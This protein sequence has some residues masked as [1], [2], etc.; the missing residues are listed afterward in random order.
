M[1][2]AHRDDAARTPGE[3]VESDHTTNQK[4]TTLKQARVQF[5][6]QHEI[7]EYDGNKPARPAYT[8]NTEGVKPPTTKED[9]SLLG[10]RAKTQTIRVEYINVNTIGEALKKWTQVM[11]LLRETDRS[12]TIHTVQDQHNSILPQHPIPGSIEVAHYATMTEL[13]NRNRQ[14]PKYASVTTIT[15]NRTIGE[16][17]R[18]NPQF[19]SNLMKLKVYVR[20][21]DL[22]TADSVEVGF[23]VGMHPSLTN[24]AWRT[25]QLR[26]VIQEEG[27]ELKLQIY[28]RKLSEGTIS[29]S[30][31]VIRCPKDEAKELEN[32]LTT[33]KPGVLGKLVEFIPYSLIRHTQD[34]SFR[35]IFSV[36]NKY[37]EDVGAIHIQGVPEEIMNL[38]YSKTT[39]PFHTWLLESKY[40][41]TVEQSAKATDKWWVITHKDTLQQLSKHLTTTVKD[42]MKKIHPQPLEYEIQPEEERFKGPSLQLTTLMERLEK[43]APTQ[44]INQP[45]PQGRTRRSYTDIARQHNQQLHQKTTQE[46]SVPDLTQV[47]GSTVS[48]TLTTQPPPIAQLIKEMADQQRRQTDKLMTQQQQQLENMMKNQ[49]QQNTLI[50]E[51]VQTTMKDMME[52]MFKQMIEVVKTIIPAL[53]QTPSINP[54]QEQ[55]TSRIPTNQYN[56]FGYPPQPNLGPPVRTIQQRLSS[57]RRPGGRSGGRGNSSKERHHHTR[58]DGKPHLSHPADGSRLG[59]QDENY[60]EENFDP[61]YSEDTINFQTGESNTLKDQTG[62]YP[63]T[64]APIR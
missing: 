20:H 57:F 4:D 37:I 24:L 55:S 40:V 53:I 6:E 3:K 19:I 62:G 47:T 44:D 63:S 46:H 45:V 25:E 51:K 26:Q 30:V 54:M 9:N 64:V 58:D 48:S 32:I 42:I 33:V 7:R 5:S 43:R 13:Q 39:K 49:Q 60:W 35:K 59:I 38:P 31:I 36:Q 14:K 34:Q 18:E 61:R 2:P 21:T 27:Q 41:L 8:G 28:Q 52:A 23:F 15:T 11:T 17:K 29:T 1:L 12:L 22:M 16:L 10:K 56:H 50:F